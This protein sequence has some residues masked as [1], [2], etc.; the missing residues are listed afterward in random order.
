[1]PPPPPPPKSLPPHPSSLPSH[2]NPRIYRGSIQ[3][4]APST[5]TKLP[6]TDG[7]S[8]HQTLL[9]F[10]GPR[11]CAATGVSGRGHS[12]DYRGAVTLR[13]SRCT[14]TPLLPNTGYPPPL[15]PAAPIRVRTDGK[16][17]SH[18][19]GATPSRTEVIGAIAAY[20]FCSGSMLLVNKLVLSAIPFRATVVRLKLLVMVACR[21]VRKLAVNLSMVPSF[22]CTGGAACLLSGN[23]FR[24]VVG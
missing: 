5:F 18:S 23:K 24:V 12:S 22:C 15:L 8:P 19:V 17:S 7:T 9:C 6:F 1:M 10:A 16:M 14:A 2:S 13:H 3:H 4:I 11:D 21:V 20:S